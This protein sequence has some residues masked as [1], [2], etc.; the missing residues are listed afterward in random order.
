MQTPQTDAP[1]RPFSVHSLDEAPSRG[2]RVNAQDFEDAALTFLEAHHPED[3]GADVSLL[4][5]DCESGERQCFRIDVA[6]GHTAP[7]DERSS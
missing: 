6:T 7:C 1:Q 4:V 2:S 5:E 3:D